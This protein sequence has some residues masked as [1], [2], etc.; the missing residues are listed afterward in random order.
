MTSQ[1]YTD[2]D[3]A[4]E[5]ARVRTGVC[6]PDAEWDVLRT[7]HEAADRA[8]TAEPQA[9]VP[10]AVQDLVDVVAGTLAIWDGYGEDE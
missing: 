7:A 10:Q 2:A 9:A 8:L 1:S 3:Y 4:A 6:P 5:A